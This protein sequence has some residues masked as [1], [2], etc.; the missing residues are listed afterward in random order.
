M[1]SY[2]ITSPDD[3]LTVAGIMKNDGERHRAENFAVA[4]RA[5]GV[6]NEDIR[7]AVSG[8]LE[9]G[10]TATL[11]GLIHGEPRFLGD[12]KL[13][14]AREWVKERENHDYQL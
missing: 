7:N 4:W 14:A 10:R 3:M 1:K 13:N 9:I 12:V 8:R 5:Q 11:Y 6:R 2:A